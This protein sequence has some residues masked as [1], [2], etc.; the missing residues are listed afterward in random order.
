MLLSLRPK[1][2][3]YFSYLSIITTLPRRILSIHHK[4]AAGNLTEVVAK[5]IDAGIGN[6][7]GIAQAEQMQ[8][9]GLLALLQVGDVWKILVDGRHDDSG[10]NGVD[11]P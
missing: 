7:L 4:I 1:Q 3:H 8:G 11:A 2:K 10:R 9:L 6:V 5:K